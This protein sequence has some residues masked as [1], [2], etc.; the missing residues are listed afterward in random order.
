MNHKKG[1]GGDE[2]KSLRCSKEGSGLTER[3]DSKLLKGNISQPYNN[4]KTIK[5][6]KYLK[7]RKS[8]E[9]TGCPSKHRSRHRIRF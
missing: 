5:G 4:M 1:G 8:I 2:V 6:G 9:H 3:K 7:N